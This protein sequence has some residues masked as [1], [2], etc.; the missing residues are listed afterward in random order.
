MMEECNGRSVP[1][2]VEECNGR[3]DHGVKSDPALVNAPGVMIDS[4]VKRIPGVK[5]A[6]AM[7]GNG[8]RDG[9]ITGVEPALFGKNVRDGRS[10][11]GGM[12]HPDGRKEGFRWISSRISR[13]RFASTNSLPMPDS[14]PA[15][16]RMS[17]SFRAR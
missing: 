4:T 17:I 14:V 6:T 7:T 8:A 1:G 2:V 12:Q 9:R 5:S 3:S 16:K 10:D 13:R 15:V 11:P